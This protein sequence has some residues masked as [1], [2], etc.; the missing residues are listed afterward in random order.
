MSRQL[1]ILISETDYTALRREAYELHTTMSVLVRLSLS[2]LHLVPAMKAI[3]V[4]QPLALV[5][6]DE[7]LP[8]KSGPKE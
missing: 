4:I 8:P 3:P 6:D 5:E 7:N 2:R 1:N